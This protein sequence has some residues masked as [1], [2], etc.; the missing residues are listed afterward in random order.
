MRHILYAYEGSVRQCLTF[1]SLEN[2]PF[3][4]PTMIEQKK[5]ADI[6]STFN[7]KISFEEKYLRTLEFQKAYLLNKM[8]I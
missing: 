7:K 6:I 3:N 1:E 2:I 8:F 5:N 4:L